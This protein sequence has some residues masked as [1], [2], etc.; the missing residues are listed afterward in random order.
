MITTSTGVVKLAM[1]TRG[2]HNM[3]H[4]IAGGGSFGGGGSSLGGGLGGKKGGISRLPAVMRKYGGRGAGKLGQSIVRGGGS[5]VK[6][7]GSVAT[8]IGSVIGS[9]LAAAGPYLA[10]AAVLYGIGEY[11]KGIADEMK[12]KEQEDRRQSSA[13]NMQKYGVALDTH[14]VSDADRKKKRRSTVGG[15][16]LKGAAIGGGAG[17]LTGAAIGS[18]IPGVGTL[19]GAG[20]GFLVGAAIGGGVGAHQG[21]KE[22]DE[23]DALVEKEN[24]AAK[25]AQKAI[26]LLE[27]NER[28]KMAAL[29]RLGIATVDVKKSILSLA[30]I[31][32]RI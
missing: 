28:E 24:A 26:E 13:M 25:E 14:V 15:Q 16:A 31:M 8:K 18:F 2:T 17:A 23:E 6:G 5:L 27:K 11:V 32:K 12:K 21:S 9:T 7:L 3:V 19:I 20:V 10:I 1:A 22:A 29:N 30:P 4:D